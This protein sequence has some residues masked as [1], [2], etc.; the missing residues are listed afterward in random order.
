MHKASALVELFLSGWKNDPTSSQHNRWLMLLFRGTWRGGIGGGE[1]FLHVS[2]HPA[3][4]IRLAGWEVHETREKESDKSPNIEA[5]SGLKSRRGNPRTKKGPGTVFKG[6]DREKLDRHRIEGYIQVS[7][8]KSY[9]TNKATLKRASIGSEDPETGAYDLDRSGGAKHDEYTDRMFLTYAD[10]RGRN[11]LTSGMTCRNRPA[12]PKQIVVKRFPRA[13]MG[14]HAMDLENDRRPI[15]DGTITRSLVLSSPHRYRLYIVFKILRL[16]GCMI[17]LRVLEAT[18][19]AATPLARNQRADGAEGRRKLRL[20]PCGPHSCGVGPTEAG[21]VDIMMNCSRSRSLYDNRVEDAFA[22]GP[23]LPSDML[24]LGK[25]YCHRAMVVQEWWGRQVVE[26]GR[27]AIAVG[28][29]WPNPQS[30]FPQRTL[31]AGDMFPHRHVAGET[32][33]FPSDMSLAKRLECCW[34]KHRML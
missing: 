6:C 33:C 2:R 16:S 5:A 20:G 25:R 28:G 30:T 26:F 1:A 14:Y 27:F 4:I 12:Q 15:Q 29:S 34:G 19:S 17:R 11:T 18:G 3:Y 22:R 23:F 24:S 10:M 9:N 21:D 8:V 13:T 31:F 7:L 32:I